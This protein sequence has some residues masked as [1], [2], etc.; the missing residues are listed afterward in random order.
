MAAAPTAAGSAG[1]TARIQ[2]A[3]Q[4]AGA[5]AV[6]ADPTGCGTLAQD[7]Q[8][9]PTRSNVWRSFLSS[10]LRVEHETEHHVGCRCRAARTWWISAFLATFDALNSMS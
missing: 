5:Y 10:L 2:G 4:G 9:G 6:A 1:E 3:A 8:C 7:L